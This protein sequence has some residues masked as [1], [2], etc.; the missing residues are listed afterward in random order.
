MGTVLGRPG[1]GM[2]DVACV[3]E[4]MVMFVP[5]YPDN[6]ASRLP[7]Y[8]PTIA[9]A[10]SNV[11]AFLAA[12]DVNASWISRLGQDAFGDFVLDELAR[13]G[14][15]VEGVVRDSARNTGVAFKEFDADGTRVHYYREGAA[16]SAMG[17][18]TA[19]LIS[20]LDPKI[21]HL[22]GVTPALSDSCAWLVHDLVHRRRSGATVSFDVNWRPRLWRHRDPSI[23]LSMARA[24]DIV[25]VGAD[26]A[27]DLWSTTGV[28]DVRQ[29]LPEPAVLVVKQGA[30]GATVYSDGGFVQVSALDV[31][32]VEVVG[33]GDAFAAGFLAG[34]L[35]GVDLRTRARFGTIL[36]AA[37]LRVP[38]DIGPIPSRSE[39]ESLLRLSEEEWRRAGLSPVP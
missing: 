34:T 10:E 19:D 23:L 18:E 29:L 15:R 37:A 35:A 5:H 13:L 9:G 8:R 39:R 17:P 26:E 31:D 2:A 11:A 27:A 25:F 12:V 33:A 22:S 21:I 24:S 6:R 38:S 36:A 20:D 4:C 1:S 3:G 28:D 30:D 16:A 7:T 14:V 32:V